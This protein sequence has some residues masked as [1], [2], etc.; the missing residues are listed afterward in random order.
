MSKLFGGKDPFDD[1]FFTEPFGGWFGWNDPFYGQ[2]GSPKQ[3]SIEELNPEG[4]GDQAQQNSET[5]R[6]LVVNNN[7]P[8]KKSNGSQSFSYRR[9]AYGGLNGMYYTCSE[10]RMMGPDGVVLAE[11]KED[12]NMIG[13]S[14]HTISK[15]IHNKGHSVT[16]KHSSD[17]QDNTLQTLHNLNEDELGDFEQNWKS[18]ADKYLPGWDKGFSLLE[19]QGSMSSLWDEFANWR[20]LGGWEHPALEYYGNGGPVVQAGESGEDSSRRARRRVPVE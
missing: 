11:M 8:R 12:D 17:G 2:Q 9:V 6:D 20:G 16:T 13:E 15:G 3:I 5:T 18:S 4:D 14:L 10:G 1:P 19:N 7:K